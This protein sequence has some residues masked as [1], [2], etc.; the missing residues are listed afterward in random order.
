[1]NGRLGLKI[2]ALACAAPA[3]LG[4]CALGVQ[5][6]CG[7]GVRRPVNLQASVIDVG[8]KAPPQARRAPEDKGPKPAGQDVP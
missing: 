6:A 3:L 2:I 5:D 4:G 7:G 1:M 8:A